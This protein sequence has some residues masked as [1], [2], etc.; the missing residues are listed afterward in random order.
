M[1]FRLPD[2]QWDDG[3]GSHHPDYDPRAD[4]PNVLKASRET[5]ELFN[6]IVKV[7]PPPPSPRTPRIP[8]VAHR[9]RKK[10]K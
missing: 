1:T 2:A 8:I 6:A 5:D 9:L 7:R 4:G 3:K 10:K